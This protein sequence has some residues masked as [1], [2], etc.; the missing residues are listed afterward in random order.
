MW[1]SNFILYVHSRYVWANIYCAHMDFT[2]THT[3]TRKHT[4]NVH[5]N[6]ILCEDSW[7][8]QL[9]STPSC[10]HIYIC[11]LVY[12]FTII[13]INESVYK[14][15]GQA[16]RIPLSAHC[17]DLYAIISC[18]LFIH[19]WACVSYIHT[20]LEISI[21]VACIY[22][23]MYEYMNRFI[24][25][26]TRVFMYMYTHVPFKTSMLNHAY[27]DIYKSIFTHSYVYPH[28]QKKVRGTV[29]R[30]GQIKM[31]ESEREYAC[32]KCAHK[33]KVIFFVLFCLRSVYRTKFFASVF[34]KEI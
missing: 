27:M 26:Q 30:T 12:I 5:S 10:A 17:V 18:G 28:K 1:Y 31:L 6:T 25:F 32:E 16:I 3:Y 19:V 8:N 23:H 14:Y 11:V 15:C 7:T 2:C 13:F 22:F 9:T 24:R 20:Y 4:C 34:Q 33:F 21:N 29:I